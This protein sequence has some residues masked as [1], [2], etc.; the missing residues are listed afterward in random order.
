MAA[1]LSTCFLA[2]GWSGVNC[3]HWN[4]RSSPSHRLLP[5]SCKMRHRNLSSQHKRQVKKL[6]P[7]RLPTNAKFQPNSEKDTESATSS[8]DEIS[9]LNHR[10]ESHDDIGTVVAVEDT[11]SDKD[12]ESATSADETSSLNRRNVSGDDVGT[13][14]AVEGTSDEDLNRPTILNEI[15]PSSTEE[16]S[17]FNH[18]PMSS[19]NDGAVDDTNEKDLNS[20]TVL[21]EIKPLATDA[22]SGED[23]SSFQI[24]DL[25]GMIKNA[26]KN[27]LLLNQAR[28][29]ALE[30]LKKIL[31]EKQELQGEINILEMRVAETDARIKVAAQEK[32]HVELLEDEMA[33]LRHG[34][35]TRG[36]TGTNMQDLHKAVPIP[37]NNSIDFLIEELSLLRKENMS[38]KDD[39]Q[40]LKAELSNVRGTDERVIILEKERS[41]LESALKELELKLHVSQEDVS[42]LFVL[43]SECKTLWEKVEHLQALLDK[44]TKKADQA[45]SV[46]QQNQELRKKVDRL[47]RSLEDANAYKSSSEKLQQYNE[48]M[49]QKIKLLEEHVQ[50]SD[51]EIHS[52]VQS[53]QESVK[54][55]QDT[56][57]SLIE[58]SKK[59][60]LDEPVDDLPWEFWSRLLL[61]ID[62]WLLEKK[63]SSN[64][65]KLLREMVWKK[66]GRICET[67]MACREKNERE[68]G[69]LGDVVTGLGKALQKRGHLVEIILPKY[70][71]MKYERIRDLRA[72]D[73]VVES[74]FDGHL[75]KNKI[76]VG[77]VEG[78]PVYFIEPHHPGN[79]FWRGQ[80]YGEHDDFKRFSFFSR[81][82]LEFLLHAGK[83]PDIIHCHDWQTAFV[84]PLYWDLYAPKGLN[85][86]RICFTCHNFEYQGTAP[87]SELAS[88]GLDVHQLNRPDRMQD[89]SAPDKIN[90]VKGAVV[91]SNIVTT[92]SP[93]YALEVQT[94]EGGRGLHLTLNSHSKKFIGILNGIDTEAWNPATDTFLKVQYSAHDLQGKAENKEALRRH[95]RLSSVNVRQPMVGCITRLV[96][97]K[98]VHLIRHAIYRTMEMGGQF[99]LLGSSPVPH[100]QREFEDIAKHFQSHE[101]IRLM[102]KYD[103]S[104]SHLIYAACDMF[105]IPSIFEPCG[106]T[107][108]IAMRYG[109]VPIARKTGGLNDS[110][111]DV[112]DDSI[113]VQFRN[114]Y[115][116]L[117]PDEQGLNG[118]LKR[119]FMHYKKSSQSWQQ[120]VQKVMNIDFSWDSSALQYEELY[121]KSVARARALASRV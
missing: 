53:Y 63:I 108:M 114:G 39:L 62:G 69:G 9:N 18:E 76:W 89:N 113:P 29:H 61:M 52:C 107:Q 19:D 120:L 4:V 33:K 116:F 95:L 68:V 75:F 98:G 10:N 70:D 64:D 6:S 77:T 88:C 87:A 92:V 22:S 43:K 50:R 93:T 117:T 65:A 23:F 31:N 12:A 17:S 5:A 112:D 38:L 84:A 103:E 118:A 86:A 37:P 78:L 24:Q 48:L 16:M 110:V 13:V 101:Q 32:V 79:F 59:R 2:Y 109:S 8:A 47:E 111:F 71:C 45:I 20:L 72:L 40:A 34:L 96:P 51:E 81:A 85:S 7:E 66:D 41:S 83:K 3:R 104:L 106:L 21:N 56:L 15:K 1:R 119:A 94:A 54:E 90:P 91:Y 49:Q 115:T 11:N 80:F 99:V 60:S 73:V 82:A 121:E 58:E 97:Q 36:G 25:I 67:Y 44:S 42:K 100:I 46:L 105:I 28:V 74:Y 30:D 14:V 27:V 35:S 102:L 26:E 55:F 57:N